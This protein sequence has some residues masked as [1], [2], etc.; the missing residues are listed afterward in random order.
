MKENSEQRLDKLTNKIIKATKLESPSANFT[1]TVMAQIEGLET[2]KIADQ[3]LIS[4]RGW[5]VVA[6]ILAGIL[7]YAFFGNGESLGWFE[8]ID[9]SFM[10][11]DFKGFENNKISETLSGITISKT[12][13][14]SVIL[15]GIIVLVQVSMF[16]TY[17]HKRF[18]F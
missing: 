18:Q 13:M 15:F 11:I 8:G 16:K 14:Y 6:I 9:F 10:G 5:I 12:L 3:P 1:S 2:I 7:S 4:K 17:F